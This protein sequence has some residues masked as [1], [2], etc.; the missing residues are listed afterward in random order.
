MVSDVAGF[1]RVY[2][3]NPGN[4][5]ALAT[6]AVSGNAC[7]VTSTSWVLLDTTGSWEVTFTV[8]QSGKVLV[9]LSAYVDINSVSYSG[10]WWLRDKATGLDV[11]NSGGTCI[12]EVGGMV[13]SWAIYVPN[14]VPNK[15]VTLQWVARVSSAGATLRVWG[16]AGGTSV[17]PA[18]MEVIEL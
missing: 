5:L 13:T 7:S 16:G 17:C 6:F 2:A 11:P 12:K 1:P 4:L 9:H 18:V 14:L 3:G 8:P 15:R 10:G